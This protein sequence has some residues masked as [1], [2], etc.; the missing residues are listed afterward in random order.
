MGAVLLIAVAW[1]LRW[2]GAR[3]AR[4]SLFVGGLPLVAFAVW[5]GQVY[6]YAHDT[7]LFAALWSLSMMG[8]V[9]GTVLKH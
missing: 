9:V 7:P 3:W 4:L 2:E 1:E 8:V 6:G 5:A